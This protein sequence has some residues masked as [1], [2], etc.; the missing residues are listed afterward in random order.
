MHFKS[1]RSISGLVLAA[2]FLV[3]CGGGSGSK[4][5]SDVK[6]NAQEY[7]NSAVNAIEQAQPQVMIIP[8][9]QLLKQ[10]GALRMVLRDGRRV[11]LRDYK[12]YLTKDPNGKAVF[13]YV[14]GAFIAENFPLNDFEQT[15]KQLDTKKAQNAAD[16]LQ[17]D[18]KTELLSVAS[19]DI[20]LEL[21]YG[22]TGQ[23]DLYGATNAKD[24]GGSKMSFTISAI[25][26]YTNKVVGTA[27]GNDLAGNSDISALERGLDAELPKLM[28]DVQQ[29]FRDILTRGRDI[30][31]RIVVE[32]GSKIDLTSINAEGDTYADYIIDYIKTNTVKGAYK[33]QSNTDKELYFVNCRIKML[34]EDGTQYGVYD[35]ARALAKS[36]R[37]DL[38]VQAVNKSQGLGEV[39]VMIKGV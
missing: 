16:G 29:Y 23:V 34:N 21:T 6:G 9:D 31:V 12:G 1:S 39:V 27:A 19:P 17:R 32:K 14:Q 4:G 18:A 35:W 26:A 24:E 5:L 28:G 8:S 13:N 3:S 2:L 25:D 38:G 37:K 20:I 10:H 15:L 7:E 11:T 22:G 33:L 30:T 36:L